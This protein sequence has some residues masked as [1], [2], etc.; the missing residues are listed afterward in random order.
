M[1]LIACSELLHNSISRYT[2]D[3]TSS[4]STVISGYT[5]LVQHAESQVDLG[6]GYS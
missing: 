4:L 2:G 5:I 1:P 3:D 6:L